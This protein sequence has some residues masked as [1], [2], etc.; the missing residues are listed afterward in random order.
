MLL[1]AGL[2]AFTGCKKSSDSGSNSGGG[3]TVE[4]TVN[5]ADLLMKV[6]ETER[7][8]ARVATTGD[9]TVFTWT[10][11][12]ESVVKVAAAS[13]STNPVALSYAN[14]TAVGLGEADVVCT[15]GDFTETCHV[16]VATE[17]ETI[18][19]EQV[20]IGFGD[21][22]LTADFYPAEGYAMTEL[23]DSL[24]T[25]GTCAL[26]GWILKGYVNVFSKGLYYDNETAQLTGATEGYMISAPINIIYVNREENPD[27]TYRDASGKELPFWSETG[28]YT[29]YSVG[30][31]S[32]DI[33]DSHEYGYIPAGKVTDENAY[34]THVKAAFAAL[35]EKDNATWET[36]LVTAEIATIEGATMSKLKATADGYSFTLLPSAI[37]PSLSMKV[38]YGNNEINRFMD[39]INGIYVQIKA[40][41]GTNVYELLGYTNEEVNGVEAEFDETGKLI[42]TNDEIIYQPLVE[43]LVPTKTKAPRHMQAARTIPAEMV[44]Y[45]QNNAKPFAPKNLIRK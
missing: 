25:T 15:A 19:F 24:L 37:I 7:I 40:F 32:T 23:T 28:K 27:A 21:S 20:Y 4:F 39:D 26:K 31:F 1:L 12:D 5:P 18:T 2:V 34:L 43:L 11:T 16:K 13:A 30:Y 41:G 29:T 22:A 45:I 8:S 35:A 38:E 10:S 44:P 42:F 9:K 3:A 6:G 33:E 14:V 17:L 36:E